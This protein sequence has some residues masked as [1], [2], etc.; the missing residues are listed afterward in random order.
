M[1]TVVGAM[2]AGYAETWLA[3]VA[4]IPHHRFQFDLGMPFLAVAPDP[5]SRRP[6]CACNRTKGW[7]DQ[8]R[9]ERSVTRPSH[10][11]NDTGRRS[12]PSS[13]L[14]SV[15]PQKGGYFRS[16]WRGFRNLWI[17]RRPLAK[18]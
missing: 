16:I 10:W 5:R 9:D 1:T 3:G 12:A 15:V 7:A 2:Q 17:N 6:E 4:T 11:P 8:A 18:D 13:A 14:S